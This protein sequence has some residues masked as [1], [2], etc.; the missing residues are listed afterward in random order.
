MA[1]WR[2][3]FRRARVNWAAH[4]SWREGWDLLRMAMRYGITLAAAGIAVGAGVAVDWEI[5]FERT[6]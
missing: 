4:G 5:L 3:R 2:M 1:S 6:E